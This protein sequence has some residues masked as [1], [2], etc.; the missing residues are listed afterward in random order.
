MLYGG[1]DI[2]SNIHRLKMMMDCLET[3]KVTAFIFDHTAAAAAGRKDSRTTGAPK[4]SV[5]RC[6]RKR[7]NENNAFNTLPPPTLPNYNKRWGKEGTPPMGIYVPL[8]PTHVCGCLFCHLYIPLCAQLH[9]DTSLSQNAFA[10]IDRNRNAGPRS[11]AGKCGGAHASHA[12]VKKTATHTHPFG[13]ASTSFCASYTQATKGRAVIMYYC[14]TSNFLG[15][16]GHKQP[17]TK[18]K[19]HFYWHDAT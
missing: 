14:H 2:I 15:C 8:S 5:H 4:R 17:N 3:K 7:P 16:V 12:T 11:G 1:V 18:K 6:T 10:Q 9:R 13:F 19:M